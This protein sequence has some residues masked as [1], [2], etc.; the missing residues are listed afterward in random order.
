MSGAIS[1]SKPMFRNGTT[2][3]VFPVSGVEW[4]FAMSIPPF[5]PGTE[6]YENACTQPTG[7]RSCTNGPILGDASTL[8]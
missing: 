1:T 3:G 4:S 8:V 7:Y 2:Y 6:L 5:S